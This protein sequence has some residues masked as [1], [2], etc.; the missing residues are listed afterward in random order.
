MSSHC[1]KR[2]YSKW[3]QYMNLYFSLLDFPSCNGTG[4]GLKGFL[5][6]PL[7]MIQTYPTV[8]T[9]ARSFPTPI[10]LTPTATDWATRVTTARLLPMRTRPMR[11]RTSSATPATL[12]S[13]RT[14]QCSL[15]VI[16]VSVLCV[17]LSMESSN[18]NHN[19]TIYFLLSVQ[20]CNLVNNNMYVYV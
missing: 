14:C 19:K 15:L 5:I 17:K 6:Y 16:Y 20:Y 18:D 4:V 8:L 13:I 2:H 3:Q 11:T 10:S 12:T 1:Q 7:T 9:T